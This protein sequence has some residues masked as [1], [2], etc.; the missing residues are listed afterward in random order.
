[1]TVKKK[2]SSNMGENLYREMKVVAK[3]FVSQREGAELYSMGLTNFRKLAEEA[4][5]VYKVGGKMIL[6][7][8]EV[9]EEY[10]ETFRVQGRY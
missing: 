1:M 7:N 9:F 2:D 6:V 8:T 10:L 5:A 4:G 3:K